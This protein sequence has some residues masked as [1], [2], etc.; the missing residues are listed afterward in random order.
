MHPNFRSDDIIPR[1]TALAPIIS[2]RYIA[3]DPSEWEVVYQP[4]ATQEQKDAVAA[5]IASL[6]ANQPSVPFSLDK[7]KFIKGLRNSG[8]LNAIRGIINQLGN[9]TDASI[10]WEYSPTIRRDSALIEQM[11][12]RLNLTDAEIDEIFL[13]GN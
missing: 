4:E 2:I 10:D 5:F 8:R 11:K 13:S 12:Q 9:D 3:N 7:G 6:D 1:L